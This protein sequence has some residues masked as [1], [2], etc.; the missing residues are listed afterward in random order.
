MSTLL[1]WLKTFYTTIGQYPTLYDFLAITQEDLICWEYHLDNPNMSVNPKLFQSTLILP[2]MY[3]GEMSHHMC[4]SGES[5]NSSI[6]HTTNKTCLSI[7]QSC[8]PSICHTT[9]K[10][11]P[12]ICQSRQL[13]VS[14]IIKMTCPSICQIYIL[15]VHHTIMMTS[16]SVHQSYITSDHCTNLT[17]SPSVCQSCQ[18]SVSHTIELTN[19]SICQPYDTSVHHTNITTRLSVCPSHQSSDHHTTTMACPS[20]CQSNHSSDSHTMTKT[21]PSLCQSHIPSV[22]HNIILTSLSI[23]PLQDSSVRQPTRDVVRPPI[24]LTVCSSSVTSILPS[25][26]SM[27]KI[28]M[29]IPERKIPNT[30]NPGKIPFGC[31]PTDSSVH[32]TGSLSINSSPSAANPS[33]FLCNSGEKNVVNCLHKNLV[34]SPSVSTSYVMS[35]IAPIHASS[36]QP[37]HTSYITSVIAPICASS[38]QPVHT[39][40]VMSVIAPLHA[41][42]IPSVNPSNDEHQEFLDGFPGTKYGEKN[43]SKIMVKF[44]DDITLTLHQV[45]FPEETPD[46]TKGVIYPGNLLST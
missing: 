25:A 43:P 46:T 38:I 6:C 16:P 31:T 19:P 37:V 30:L 21:S 9:N 22:C 35:V 12:S 28:H 20:V 8:Q 34:K 15:S 23:C 4:D 1:L 2:P 17:T 36:I 26:N 29:S 44:P 24:W 7:C 5:N 14:H 3:S 45:K 32:H 11:C 41:L 18:S 42:P 10:I 39:S 33:K 40:C 13:S 27:V